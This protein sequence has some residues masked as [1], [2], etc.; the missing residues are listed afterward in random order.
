MTTKFSLL[1]ELFNILSQF[2]DTSTQ[3]GLALEMLAYTNTPGPTTANRFNTDI[4][5]PVVC[6]NVC[7]PR[8]KCLC[9]LVALG[10]EKWD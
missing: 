8:L 3:T 6:E 1:G 4:A 5:T 2:V 9:M 10:Q 7:R